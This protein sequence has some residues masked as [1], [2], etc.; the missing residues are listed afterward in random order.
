MQSELAFERANKSGRLQMNRQRVLETVIKAGTY[1]ITCKELAH[2]YGLAM[3][4]VS[5]RFTELKKEGKIIKIPGVTRQGS[6]VCKAVLND[7][8][9]V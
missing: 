2:E 3:H 5:G 6:A 1:G 9:L 8:L 4:H 7:L